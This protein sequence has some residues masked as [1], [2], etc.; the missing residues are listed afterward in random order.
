[1]SLIAGGDGRRTVV[2]TRTLKVTLANVEF[3]IAPGASVVVHSSLSSQN[4][5]LLSR[6]GGGPLDV[7]LS[8]RGVTHRVVTL[9]PVGAAG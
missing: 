4:R 1:M 2:S 5:T 8:G 6:L 7:M 9:V 3:A